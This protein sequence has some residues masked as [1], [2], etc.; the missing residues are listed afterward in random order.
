MR[1]VVV[2]GLGCLTPVGNTPYEAFESLLKGQSGLSIIPEWQDSLDVHIAGRVKNFNPE[3]WIEPQKDIR[4]M[5]RFIQFSL[6]A[7]IQAWR[8]AGLPDKLDNSSGNRAGTLVGIGL[9][10]IHTLLESYE[11]L[12]TKGPDRV[13]AFF[14][15][16][17]IA[18]LSPG[19]LA[20]RFNLR[21][22]NWTLASAC[23]SGSHGIGEAFM[24]IRDNRADVM[25]AGGSE[26]GLHPLAVAGFSSMHALCKDYNNNPTAAS[27]PFDAKRCGF[28]MSEGAGVM[29][30]EELQHAQKRGAK[31]LAEITGYGST[32]DAH[33]ITTP[34][35]QGEGAQRA[36]Q[37]ALDM[38]ELNPDQV[39]YINAHGTSTFYNDRC[40]TEAIKAV[41]GEHAR[42]LAISSTKSMT[43]HLLGAAGGVEAVFSVMSILHNQVPPTINLENPDPACDLDYVPGKARDL[44][45][46]AAMSNSFGF[47]GTNAVLLFQKYNP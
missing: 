18:N 29:V 27:R 33:H 4:R 20:I 35:E 6:A 3:D 24:H 9:M 14:I 13:S 37:Q 7:G 28:V 43:G 46:N 44:Q 12:K 23:A 26:S 42:K 11:T 21:G 17:I 30:L 5:D 31:I 32:S 39:N 25:L 36:M 45:V 1:R 19:H 16:A 34:S 8:Q 47:G 41:F 15:P 22:P 2:T 10:G 38:A 40:E